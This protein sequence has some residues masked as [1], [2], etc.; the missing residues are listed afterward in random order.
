MFWEISQ[1]SQENTCATDSFLVKL[2]SCLHVNFAKFLRTPFLQNT[3]GRLL[4]YIYLKL[5]LIFKRVFI[6]TFLFQHPLKG[7]SGVSL[8]RL[9]SISNICLSRTKCS[10]PWNFPQE[11]CIAFLYFELLYLELFPT[12]FP[13][14]WNIFSLYLQHLDTWISFSNSR[15]NSNLNQNKNFDRK[16]KKICFLFSVSSKQKCSSNVSGIRKLWQ[17]ENF[18]THRER[19]DK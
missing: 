9:P 19:H 13:V 15:I 3:F 12:N 1:N 2:Q 18:V 4:L 16:W 10:I 17:K 5:E 8:S 6:C 11:H 7:D 14:P